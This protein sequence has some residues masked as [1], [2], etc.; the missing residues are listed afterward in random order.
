MR[1]KWT[2]QI[3]RSIG[4]SLEWLEIFWYARVY[5]LVSQ[6]P[7][8]SAESEEFGTICLLYLFTGI[9]SV[10]V[11]SV[12]VGFDQRQEITHTRIYRVLV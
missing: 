5:S 7:L 3:S 2:P 12:F 8:P 6:L 11:D 9:A 10:F 1:Q 4:Y